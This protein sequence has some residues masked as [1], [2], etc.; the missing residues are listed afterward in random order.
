MLTRNWR[1]GHF[2]SGA[3]LLLSTL[4]WAGSA[5][6]A[7]ERP[8]SAPAP[9]APE[10][11]TSAA[12]T[13]IAFYR[14]GPDRSVPLVVLS[15][16]PGSDHRYMRIRG[17]FDRLAQSRKV[18]FLDQRGTAKSGDAGAATTIDLYVD[19]VEAVRAAGAEQI[20][21]IGH[22]FGGYLGIAYAA[23]HPERVR[24]LSLIASAP[25]RLGEEKQ[26][27]AEVFPDRIE[28]WRAKRPQLQGS[29]PASEF[30]IFQSMEFVD[31]AALADFLSGVAGYV[32][33]VDSNNA[34]RLD[35]Q[36]R[37]YW[38]VLRGFQFPMLVMHGRY[39]AVLAIVNSWAIHKASPC[40]E[41]FVFED[42]GH[43]P[44]VERPEDFLQKMTSFL[45]RVDAG[46]ARCSNRASA[47]GAALKD[48]RHNRRRSG[49]V[50]TGKSAC[51]SA[52]N[53]GRLTSTLKD[54]VMLPKV[55]PHAPSRIAL[56]SPEKL[57]KEDCLDLTPQVVVR[58]DSRVY[59][60]SM[61]TSKGA[62]VR[63]SPMEP[64]ITLI[65][66]PVADLKR[67]V[68]FYAK[69]GWKPAQEQGDFVLY[70]LRGLNLAL[71]PR[72]ALREELG[73]ENAEVGPA[74]LAYNVADKPAVA[75]IFAKAVEAG[76]RSVRKP[77]DQFWGGYSGIFADPEGNYWEVAYNPLMALDGP[78]AD[79]TK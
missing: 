45:A 25:P 9:M 58:S 5:G 57:P 77:A 55:P 34:L 13:R 32:Y 74:A 50:G 31:R 69:V 2:P 63:A 42:A 51:P 43:I 67:A 48:A 37:D 22:S 71:Y 12:A 78:Q 60:A 61:P 20:D 44:H 29:V 75:S 4:F 23:R 11:A 21:L 72:G 26:L 39:D 41:F 18:I 1:M 59:E 53:A 73:S 70:E 49:N 14:T 8:G 47:D 36:K 40:S 35:M 27:L 52:A 68:D 24:S 64:R 56:P 66:L 33:N 6:A 17:G 10:F 38:S 30:R 7:A 46:A 79:A 28:A 3:A 15:G 19:D 76:G 62:A 16:G 65:T 54:V